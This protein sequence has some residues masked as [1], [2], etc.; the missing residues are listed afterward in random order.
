MEPLA[1]LTE[2]KALFE[3]HGLPCALHDEW[4]VPNGEFP[5]VRALWHPRETSGRLDVQVWLDQEACIEEC[6]AGIGS[7][8]DGLRDALRNFAI[9]SFHVLLAAIWQQN[10]P[11]QVTTERWT[12]D[13]RAYTAYV[14][15]FGTRATEGTQPHVPQEL[16]PAIE[17]ALKNTRLTGDTHWARFFFCNLD[18]EQTFEALLDNQDWEDGLA[19]L[20]SVPWVQCAGYYSVRLFI[21]L[22]ASP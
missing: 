10:D 5:G 12:L 4:L 2:L 19:C 21:V 9:N 8:G 14:G 13:G 18:G 11:D 15:N 20:Q 6:F 3:G 17:R 7:G 16:F 1:P 22:R